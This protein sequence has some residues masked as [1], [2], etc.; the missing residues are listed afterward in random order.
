MIDIT[1]YL[2]E[3]KTG[4]ELVDALTILPEYDSNICNQNV[5]TRLMAL[6]DLY[7]IYVPSEMSV[8]IYNK[9]YLALMRSL[10]KKYTKIAIRQQKENHKA[11]HAQEY[12]SIIGG[13]DSFTIIGTSGIGKSSAISR[14]IA[15][16]TENRIIEIT[17]PY[18]K[19]IPCITVQCPWDSSVKGLLLEILRKVDEV[20]NSN[21]Y[22]NA[23]RARATTDMLIGSVSQVAL[24]HIG[25]LIVDEI[26]NVCNSR[27]GKSLVGMLTQ[28]IN[29]SGISIAMIGTPESTVFFQQALQLARRSLGLKY[30][31]MPYGD[32]YKALCQTLFSYQYT[33][34]PCRLSDGITEWLYEHSGGITSTVVSLVHDAQ[35]IAIINGKDAIDI[36]LLNTAYR[37]RMG[38]LH[39]YIRPHIKLKSQ[40]TTLPRETEVIQSIESDNEV[41]NPFLIAKAAMRSK[42]EEIDIVSILKDSFPIDEVVL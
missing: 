34:Q 9:L 33:T 23:V 10:Q 4:K 36:D 41:E 32:Y 37:N 30:G 14:A 27:N 42:Y 8:E 38:M 21:Y 1:A 29:N 2:P 39:D 12:D 15:L 31:A 24:N 25:I 20:L 40:T 5:A 3:M 22:I 11:I 35:E 13:S 28:L 7:K 26:Q 17:S 19:I 16:I 6:S 18:I